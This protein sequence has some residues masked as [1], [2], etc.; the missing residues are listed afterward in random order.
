VS[1]EKREVEGTPSQERA[2]E[3]RLTV[4]ERLEGSERQA[5][6]QIR[7]P[8]EHLSIENDPGRELL[9]KRTGVEGVQIRDETHSSTP[10]AKRLWMKGVRDPSSGLLPYA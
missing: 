1:F 8:D 9:S 6:L 7:I 5:L 4:D 3:A 2:N 10:S